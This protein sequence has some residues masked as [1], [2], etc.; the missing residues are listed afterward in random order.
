MNS[1]PRK[2]PRNQETVCTPASQKDLIRNSFQRNSLFVCYNKNIKEPYSTLGQIRKRP[3]VHENNTNTG[4][5]N[6]F[7]RPLKIENKTN[8]QQAFK[9]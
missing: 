9:D 5:G 1:K 4:G 6:T 2:L 7:N 8:K 3:H